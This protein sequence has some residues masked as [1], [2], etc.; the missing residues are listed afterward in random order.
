MMCVFVEEVYQS[1]EVSLLIDIFHKRLKTESYFVIHT[2][3]MNHLF[4]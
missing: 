1:S 2:H 4:A 3:H